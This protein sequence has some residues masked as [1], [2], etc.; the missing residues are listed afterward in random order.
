M[1]GLDC[2]RCL[3]RELSDR[4]YVKTVSGYISHIPKE[5][6]TPE[7]TYKYR[8][9]Q[10]KKCQY[11]LNGLCRLC[12]CFVEIRAAVITNYCPSTKVNW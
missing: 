7:E 8:L 9:E 4:D 12:G 5:L 10:C 3:L 1:D 11:L 6:R 2:E